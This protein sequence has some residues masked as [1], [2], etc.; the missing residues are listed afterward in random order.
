MSVVLITGATSGHG[1]Y[2]ARRLAAQH[3][4]LVHG[5]DRERTQR[6]AAELGGRAYVA[7]LGDL[8]E[9]RRLAAE[10]AADHPTVD[11][12]INN[13]GIG[14]GT[15]REL[16]PDGHELHFAVMY[17]APVL[18]TRE[19]LPRITSNVLNIASMGQESIDFDDLTMQRSYSGVTAYRRAKLALIMATFDLA[20]RRPD[21]H[22]NAVHPAT[23]MDTNIVRRGGGTP[24]HTV[25]YG[26]E[27]TLRVLGSPVTG[28][29]FNEDRP[30]EAHP[31]AYRPE[32]RARLRRET[33]KIAS[34]S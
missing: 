32:L 28:R 24:Q 31:D 22:V 26:G 7:D 13:A 29:F 20:E 4:V 21:L 15:A 16:S 18:L 1:R 12:L 34:W 2:L 17:L 23:Y 14:Y 27:H 30:A 33:D 25:E 9:V 19:L 5:R 11:V 8:T 3:T 6:F 10:V